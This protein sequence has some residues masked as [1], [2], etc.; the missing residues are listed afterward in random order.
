MDPKREI[1]Y[2]VN[3]LQFNTCSPVFYFVFSLSD[4]KSEKHLLLRENLRST[5]NCKEVGAVIIPP[6]RENFV[7]LL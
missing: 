6:Q 7:S 1:D 4:C 5:V 2:T 3:H